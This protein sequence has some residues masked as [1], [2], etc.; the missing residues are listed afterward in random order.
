MHGWIMKIPSWG[1]WS[2]INVFHRVPYNPIPLEKQ[3]DPIASQGGSLLKFLRKLIATCDFTGGGGPDPY[4]PL[5]PPMCKHVS[6]MAF[7]PI[8]LV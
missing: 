5:N 7:Q 3:L 1:R 2:L 4:P 6:S 8:Y